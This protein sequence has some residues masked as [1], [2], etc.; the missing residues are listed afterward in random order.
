MTA[1]LYTLNEM[2]MQTIK[3]RTINSSVKHLKY[4]ISI[5]L[6]VSFSKS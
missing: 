6:T 1:S 5:P 2:K 4:N 3:S